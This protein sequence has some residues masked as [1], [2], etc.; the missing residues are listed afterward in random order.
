MVFMEMVKDLLIMLRC[1]D[2]T[3]VLTTWVVA[4]ASPDLTP[5]TFSTSPLLFAPHVDRFF[6]QMGRAQ[7]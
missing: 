3:M 7:N 6:V 5:K 1:M 4:N 2:S